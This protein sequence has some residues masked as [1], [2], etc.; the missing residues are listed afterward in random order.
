MSR[1]PIGHKYKHCKGTKHPR[2]E[3]EGM[4]TLV[5]KQIAKSNKTESGQFQAETVNT[6]LNLFELPVGDLS[7]SVAILA[8]EAVIYSEIAGEGADIKHRVI[9]KERRN[10]KAEF[11]IFI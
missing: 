4:T 10:V 6:C 11:N 2:R 5:M 9:F 7:R 1:Q 8:H 3:G